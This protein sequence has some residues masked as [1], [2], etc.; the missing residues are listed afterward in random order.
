V[1]NAL[2]FGD[3][4]HVLRRYVSADSVDLIYLDP[5][6]N[7]NAS[8]SVLF[9]TP[10][11][12]R[13]RA[14]VDAFKDTWTWGLRAETALLEIEERRPDIFAFLDSLIGF[15]GKTDMMAYV[16][17]MSVRLIEMRRVLK[18]T[19]TLYLHCDPTA[20]HYLRIV[21]D[22]IFG[23]ANFRSEI[24]WRRSASHNKLSKQYGPIHDTILFYSK[25]ENFVFHPGHTP[26]TRSYM[27]KMF[28]QADARGRYRYNE[29]TGQGIRMQ[30]SG[31]PWRGWDPTGRGRHWAIP[32]SLRGE[33]STANEVM[34]LH[35]QLDL[36]YERGWIVFSPDGRPVYK[37]YAGS[38]VFY[39]DMWAYQP[40]TE[41]IFD[42]S[43]EAIDAD[44]KWLDSEEERLGY[45]TQKPLGLL[46]RIISTSS[47]AGDLV[48]DPFC[49][50]G[51]AVHAA[52]LLGRRWI[53]IDITHVAIQIIEDRLKAAFPGKIYEVKGRPTDPDGA[54]EL[55][56]RDKYQFQFWA[57]SMVSGQ[58]RGGE[59]RKGADHGIDGEL[60]FKLGSKR[61][62]RAVIS[63]KGGKDVNP[64]KVREL[65]GTR[66]IHGADA[67]VLIC[68]DEP[69]E[70]MKK[71]AVSD[72]VLDTE[73]GRFERC[74]IVSA[75]RL[76]DRRPLDLPLILNQ[77]AVADASRKS[78]VKK[79]PKVPTAEKLRR[80]PSFKLPIKGGKAKEAQRDLP[81]SE[82]LLVSSPLKV[83][84]PRKRTN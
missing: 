23:S 21:L 10:A 55:A 17:M 34:T 64:E 7:S 80:Q 14:Q 58:P 19:G 66:V 31:R 29:L 78:A 61:N 47:N 22:C 13:S 16:V 59:E 50:C 40:G 51:T 5:P 54:R 42:A 33:I 24:V 26:Y 38:G 62:G 53:G 49:G 43:K 67:A 4:L 57:V 73:F 75:E 12:V 46:N 25:S 36:L 70:E 30:E 37:Q 82:P 48:L 56:K 84:R 45:P 28:R 65:I 83:R 27:E 76:F 69:T 71:A 20:G 8:Y 72:G 63:V 41:G 74:Q 77:T 68:V 52:Q 81:L 79:R 32:A 1:V 6:F 2:Y 18:P 11:G 44:V 15:V 35:Q 39:Q 3:N 60:F 9:K